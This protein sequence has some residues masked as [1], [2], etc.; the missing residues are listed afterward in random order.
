MVRS[1]CRPWAAA[2]FLAAVFCGRLPAASHP[3]TPFYLTFSGDGQ[4]VEVPSA[5]DLSFSRDGFTVSAWL[6]PDT[7]EFSKTEGSGYVYWMGKGERG[8]HEWATR[9]YSYTNEERPPRPN[10]ISFYLFNLEG[11]LGEGSFF[12]EP[13]RVREWIHMT[14]VAGGGDTA[15]YRD[16]EYVRCD[17]Y[18]GPAGHGCA[19]H[20]E[21]IHPMPGNAPLR[22]GTRDLKSFFQGGLS[23]VRIW[24]RQL[25]AVEIRALYRNNEVPRRG[26]AAEFLLDEGK[27]DVAH[28][29]TGRHE[30]KIVG[31]KWKKTT[32]E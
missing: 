28:D 31:A 29:T 9:M 10:R 1:S 6:K 21:R 15:I 13:V 17:E 3:A 22:L 2:I 26:L 4:Y 27:G 8:R 20:G 16:G 11:G 30:G 19:S 32:P 18:N 7:L 25:S 12:Q 14:A 24:N 5:P 23:Q